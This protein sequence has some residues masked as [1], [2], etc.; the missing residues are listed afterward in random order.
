[1]DESVII[2]TIKKMKASGLEDDIILSTLED[3]GI[4]HNR[5]EMLLKKASGIPIEESKVEGTAQ[6]ETKAEKAAPSEEIEVEPEKMAE[7]PSEDELATALRQ[8]KEMP[9]KKFGPKPEHELIAEKAAEKVKQHLEETKLEH[10]LHHTTMHA[11]LAQQ[12]AL[13]DEIHKSVREVK[14]ATKQPI[15]APQSLEEKIVQMQ[16]DIEKIKADLA[17]TKAMAAATK[18]LMDKVLEVTRKILLRLP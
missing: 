8:I 17:E 2:D 5:A 14:E 9:E 12:G 16:V 15:K 18:N 7:E 11:A 3:I 13:L 4:S 1:M 10:D 6:Q